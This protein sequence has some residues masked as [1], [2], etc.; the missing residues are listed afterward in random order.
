MHFMISNGLDVAKTMTKDIVSG[1][2]TNEC[3]LEDYFILL[4]IVFIMGF[5]QYCDGRYK[6]DGQ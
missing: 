1:I 5:I 4:A 2:F 3:R 6:S